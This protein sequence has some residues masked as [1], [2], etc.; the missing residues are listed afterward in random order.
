MKATIFLAA[1]L[2]AAAM[3]SEAAGWVAAGAAADSVE[4]SGGADPAR[5]DKPSPGDDVHLSFRDYV[6]RDR[7]DAVGQ[8]YLAMSL[9]ITSMHWYA[10]TTRFE[11]VLGGA[12]TAGTLGMFVGAVGTSLGWFD[13]ETSWILTGSMAA[14]GALYGGARYEDQ[15]KLRYRIGLER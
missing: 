6:L 13:E 14:V 9:D 15:P 10:P 4:N 3:A 11:A 8:G 2:A 1:L 5:A 12:G 7:L